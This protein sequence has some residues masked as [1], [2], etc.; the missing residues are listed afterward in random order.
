M[1]RNVAS[2][3]SSWQLDGWLVRGWAACGLSEDDPIMGESLLQRFELDAMVAR[4]CT[5]RQRGQHRPRC[6]IARRQPQDALGKNEAPRY[7][8]LSRWG[9]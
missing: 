5:R 2:A 6:R 7:R 9:G 4:W 3:T 8:V 1:S